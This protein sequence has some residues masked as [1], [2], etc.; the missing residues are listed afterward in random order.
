MFWQQDLQT[1]GQPLTRC[2]GCYELPIVIYHP[3]R[4]LITT[5]EK[6]QPNCQL[7]K[8]DKVTS[9]FEANKPFNERSRERDRSCDKYDKQVQGRVITHKTLTSPIA[10]CWI[11]ILQFSDEMES[12]GDSTNR[13][14]GCAHLCQGRTSHPR[15]NYVSLCLKNRIEIK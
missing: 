14:K 1:Y 15:T 9:K 6:S 11:T 5:L 3:Q 13:T 12:A 7:K 4:C 2:S 8:I 10:I